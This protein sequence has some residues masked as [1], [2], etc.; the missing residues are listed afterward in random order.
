M[1]D[2]EYIASRC[3]LNEETGCWEWTG[4]IS[5]AGYGQCRRGG[6]VRLAHRLAFHASRKFWPNVCRHLCHNRLC[7]NPLHLEDGT[8]AD[9]ARDRDEAGRGRW[10]SGEEHANAKAAPSQME[11]IDLLAHGFTQTELSEIYGLG[12]TTI[13]RIKNGKHWVCSN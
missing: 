6:S 8:P 7:C 2:I 1:D 12:T 10:H 5:P 9:N 3:N 13:S 4:M 11:V